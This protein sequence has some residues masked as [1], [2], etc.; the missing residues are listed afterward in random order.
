V[1]VTVLLPSFGKAIN[2]FCLPVFETPAQYRALSRIAKR[3]LRFGVEVKKKM[4][5]LARKKE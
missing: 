2:A 4:T 3:Q 5:T 1:Q